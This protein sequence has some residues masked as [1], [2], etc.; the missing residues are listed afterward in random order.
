[1]TRLYIELKSGPQGRH[2]R[3]GAGV[4]HAARGPDHGALRCALALHRVGSGATRSAS[5]WRVASPTRTAR[6]LLGRRRQPHPL[7]Q[8]GPGHEHVHA[9]LVEPGVESSTWRRAGSPGRCWWPATRRSAA[10][11]PS[12]W[13][14]LTTSTPTTSRAATPRRWRE[15]S[16]TNVRF[17]SGVGAE[18]GASAI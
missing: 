1:M 12:T 4:H 18:Y 9:R 14:T 13:S 2:A 6:V 11:S 3:V 8:V 10:R 7:A 15:I 5:A 16:G 17:I